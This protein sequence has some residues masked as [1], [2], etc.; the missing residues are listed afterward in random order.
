MLLACLC[1]SS[2]LI[3]SGV[4]FCKSPSCRHSDGLAQQLSALCLKARTSSELKRPY[5]L[6]HLGSTVCTRGK[7]GKSLAAPS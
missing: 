2:S 6:A 3:F 4:A 1:L 7:E 5:F